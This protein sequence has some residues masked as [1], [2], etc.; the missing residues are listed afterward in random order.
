ME[1]I[2]QEGVS[3]PQTNDLNDTINQLESRLEKLQPS[4][5]HNNKQPENPIK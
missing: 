5:E 3:T 4:S 2:D 1:G